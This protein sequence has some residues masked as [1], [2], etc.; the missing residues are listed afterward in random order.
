MKNGYKDLK[1]GLIGKKLGHSFSPMIHNAMADY[2]F[3]LYEL[4]P[5]EIESF[6]KDGDLD[7]FCVTIPYK[8]D[9][10][11]FLDEIS[12][13]ALDIGAV[14]VVVRK[15][16]KLYGYNTDYFGFDYMVK[17][18]S[19]E[20]K[21]KKAI[22]FGRGGASATI[23]T[24]LRDKGVSELITVGIEDNTPENLAKHS[25][26]QI[27]VNA[28]PVGMYPNNYVSPTS[29]SYFPACEAVFDL[30]Y[31]P[32]KTALMLEAE[33]LGITAV[34]GLSMLVAQAARA[35]EHFTGDEY[36]EGII[37]KVVA[38]ITART[39]NLILI[40]MPG[41]GKSSVGKII[42]EKLG[43][44]LLD[45]DEGFFKMHGITP[46]DAINTLGEEKF[47]LLETETLAEISKQSGKVI[48]TGGG[49]VTKERNYPL[50]HQ[51]GVIVF[52]DR[53]LS[54]LATD[55]RPLSQKYSLEALYE[56]RIG[57]YRTFADL[58]VKSTEIKEL[59]ADAIVSAFK[60]FIEAK[61]QI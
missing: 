17:C 22:V 43:R 35:F 61:E 54:N 53:E 6:I 32:S 37:E 50:L 44:E 47:R 31:N 29:L 58:T 34:G 48:A 51:N 3:E 40:G 15:D 38:D 19:V 45:S 56:K 36:E 39:A 33:K 30:I 23:C 1:C 57:F 52:L 20:V 11:P 9:V 2:P 55:G 18:S 27:V 7:A 60:N 26:A 46:A 49:V 12:K 8:K 16:G 59:T 4:E 21:G 42:A 24:L 41:C 13:E 5:E 10:M 25:D 14:N 28:T